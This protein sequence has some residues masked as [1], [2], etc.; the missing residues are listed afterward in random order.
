M[1]MQRP[2]RLEM[3]WNGRKETTRRNGLSGVV[4]EAHAAT[5]TKGLLVVV[6][7]G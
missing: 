4:P 1:A 3:L 7:D 6:V 5:V 2:L